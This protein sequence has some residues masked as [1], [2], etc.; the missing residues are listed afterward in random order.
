MRLTPSLTT[1]WFSANRVHEV[2]A[3]APVKESKKGRLASIV[4]SSLLMTNQ[5]SPKS[6]S[7]I[8]V[9]AYN[10]LLWIASNSFRLR[11][12]RSCT[13]RTLG[14]LHCAGLLLCTINAEVGGLHVKQAARRREILLRE[15]E[16]NFLVQYARP[17]TA[18][19]HKFL[20]LSEE[21]LRAETDYAQK[22]ERQSFS[23]KAS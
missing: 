12:Q 4:G 23:A 2:N 7:N 3:P 8:S 6:L 9:Y 21:F 10:P 20:L 22:R 19:E 1:F 16:A 17:M 5:E 14:K 15:F 11:V 18:Q 13:V